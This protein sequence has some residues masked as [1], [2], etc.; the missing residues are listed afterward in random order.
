[1]DWKCVEMLQ[2]D[3]SGEWKTFL[4]FAIPLNVAVRACWSVRL[5]VLLNGHKGYRQLGSYQVWS[6][7]AGSLAIQMAEIFRRMLWVVGR[8]GSEQPRV[9][10]SAQLPM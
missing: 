8:V 5:F 1:M 4:T 9:K 3:G 6:S 10:Y 2:G 7:D